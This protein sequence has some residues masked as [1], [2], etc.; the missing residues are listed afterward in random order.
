MPPSH[1]QIKMSQFAFWVGVVI[2]IKPDETVPLNVD[3]GRFLCFFS[4]LC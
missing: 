1:E 4:L 2:I 3:D